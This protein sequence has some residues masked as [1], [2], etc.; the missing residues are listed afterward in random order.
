[1]A[2]LETVGDLLY[3]SYANLAMATDAEKRGIARYD[4]VGWMIRARL[5]KGLRDATMNVG[6]LFA[7][8]RDLPSDRCVYCAAVPPPKLQADHL[9][10]RSR[11]GP[12]SGDNLVWACAPCNVRKHA[13][14][15]LEWYASQSRLPPLALLRRYLKLALAE[16]REQRLMDTNL[17]ERPA[18]KF[19]LEHVP[20]QYP[21]PGEL[22][23]TV[24][25]MTRRIEVLVPV[26]SRSQTVG[27]KD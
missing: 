13:R 1:V 26:A 20:T 22:S 9:I 8:V 18:V 24:E 25:R 27:K 14:D 17:D 23:W 4:R 15:L 7:D 19:S 11:G 3:W 12:E 10:P 2:A 6:S 5:F 21:Q 16:A